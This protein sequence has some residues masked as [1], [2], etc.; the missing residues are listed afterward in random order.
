MHISYES[1]RSLSI[2]SADEPSA[3]DHPHRPY[4]ERRH[5]P[6]AARL[7]PLVLDPVE[8]AVFVEST[9][10]ASVKPHVASGG[11]RRLGP[12][13]VAAEHDVG[14]SRPTHDLADL[15]RPLLVVIP[16]EDPGV[17]SRLALTRTAGS[18]VLPT[19]D[20]G[21]KPRLRPPERGDARYL[22]SEPDAP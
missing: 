5:A 15:T 7:A 22:H 18:A 3:P 4:R 17:E 2:R 8:E 21:Q 6:A 12:V 14:L 19:G 9:G 13:P 10:L 1:A 20:R 16:V 11:D